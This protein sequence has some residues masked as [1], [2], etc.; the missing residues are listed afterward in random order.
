MQHGVLREINP[1]VL[2]PGHSQQRSSGEKEQ[3]RCA[4]AQIETPPLAEQ[5]STFRAK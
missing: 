1:D 5:A 3:G 4:E 2:L